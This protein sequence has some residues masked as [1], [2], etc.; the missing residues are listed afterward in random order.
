MRKHRWFA[1]LLAGMMAVLVAVPGWNLAAAKAEATAELPVW[2]QPFEETVTLDVVIGWDA[3][4]SIKEGTTPETNALRTVAKDLFNIELNFLWMVPNDQYSDKLALQL[5]SGDMPDILM[6]DSAYFYEFLDS[7]YLRDLTDAYNTYA[8]DELK[9]TIEYFGEAPVT[10]SSRDGKLYGIPA[11]LDT[12]E[13]VAG[14][15]YRSDWLEALNMEVPTDMDGVNDMLIALA[16]YGPTVNGGQATAGLGSTSN[17]LNTNFALSAYFQ[18]YGSYPG[19]W[20]MRDGQLVNGF[21]LDETLDALKGLKYLY[22]NGGLAPDFATWNSDQFEQR[23]TNDQVAA[24]FGTYYIAAYPLNLNKDANHDAEWAEI[25]IS[26]LGGNAKAAMNQVSINHF[27][28]VTKDAPE[29]A[30]AALMKLL[31][32]SLS[33]NSNSTD[34]KTIYKG[35]DLPENGASIFF[36]PVYMYFPTP[37]EQYRENIWAAYEAQDPS[38]LNDYLTSG[39]DCENLGTA[40]GMYKSRLS[41]DMGIAIGLATK[42]SGNYEPGYFYGAATPTEARVSATLNDLAVSFVVEYIMGQKTD[43]NWESF[44]QSW[45]ELGGTDWTNEVNAQYNNIINP[46]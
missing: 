8:S 41:D 31:S 2:Q 35:L 38:N 44:K 45:Y 13:S 15:Y 6:L 34:D 14:L 12:S 10:Y 16:N 33:A 18:C 46:Q 17:V 30:E 5:S 19:K 40:W 32:L 24:T 22:D 39:N 4:P 7:G 20:V 29:N 9:S 21:M 1:L 26:T 43:E 3:D 27:N 25:D 28:V 23:V 36:L 11:L 42:N 37:W